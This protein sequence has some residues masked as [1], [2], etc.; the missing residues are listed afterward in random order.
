MSK[1]NTA[2]TYEDYVKGLDKLE[3]EQQLSLVELVTANIKKQL[4]PKSGKHKISE[5]DGLGAEV[6]NKIET[7]QYIQKERNS[8]D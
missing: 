2:L 4:Q 1:K 3:P 7:K 8:W 6:W 5:L